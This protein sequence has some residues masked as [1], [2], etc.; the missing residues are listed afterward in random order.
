[1][2]IDL[3]FQSDKLNKLERKVEDIERQIEDRLPSKQEAMISG[4]F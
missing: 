2:I 1:L 4:E 3:F